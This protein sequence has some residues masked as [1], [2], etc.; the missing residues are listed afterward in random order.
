[1]SSRK[2]KVKKTVEKKS[3][4]KV[5]VKPKASVRQKEAQ[6]LQREVLENAR[7]NKGD[8]EKFGTP[9]PIDKALTEPPKQPGHKVKKRR[10]EPGT[11]E[12]LPRGV[13]RKC[14]YGE[15]LYCRI[16]CKFFDKKL[17]DHQFCMRE[18]EKRTESSEAERYK[19][20]KGDMRELVESNVQLSAA[21]EDLVE[22]FKKAARKRG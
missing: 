4:K 9:D 19:G 17:V 3:V 21:V 12:I 10:Y 2:K 13:F 22:F 16:Y 1:M 20:I 8:V 11:R 5:P 14:P 7:G 18:H 6:A 15:R